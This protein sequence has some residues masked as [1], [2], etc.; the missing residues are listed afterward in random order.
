M[1]TLTF[2]SFKGG[3]GRTLALMNVAVALAKKNKKVVVMDF[4][5]EAPGLH[6]F[7]QL[8]PKKYKEG[9]IL[10]F[11]KAYERS[12]ERGDPDLFPSIQD[13]LVESKPIKISKKQGDPNH[14]SSR[15]LPIEEI[16]IIDLL[17]FSTGSISGNRK[18]EIDNAGDQNKIWLMPAKGKKSDLNVDSVNWR[19]LVE[20]K[21]GLEF[22]VELKQK[23]FEYTKADYL[24]I[25]SRTGY[26][27]HS[28]IST[29]FMADGIAIIFF[30]NEQNLDG[31]KEIVPEIFEAS[32]VEKEN[33]IFVA[34]RIPRGD[35]DKGILE[36]K[37]TRF[38]KDL[39]ITSYI[40]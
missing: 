37:M 35:D 2:Y 39:D 10:D 27:D 34:S 14:Y 9:G 31:L 28:Y 13:Y 16:E 4:D 23:I 7:N 3:V 33:I 19:N 40:L 36:A 18:N 26:A 1:F 21:H 29:N 17:D 24:L 15:N 30:P 11:V 5:L 8:F 38:Q 22:L 32:S 12:Y 25:D 20:Q 6:T